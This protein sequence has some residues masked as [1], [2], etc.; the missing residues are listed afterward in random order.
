[1]LSFS[2]ALTNVKISTNIATEIERNSALRALIASAAGKEERA[3]G[4]SRGGKGKN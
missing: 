4:C 3:K 1:M 2:G